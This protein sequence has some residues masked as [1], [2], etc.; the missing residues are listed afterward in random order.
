MLKHHQTKIQ[1]PIE[2]SQRRLISL[3]KQKS[4]DSHEEKKVFIKADPN[5]LPYER[6]GQYV[7]FKH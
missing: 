4:R 1:K 7:S 3:S 5:Y 6:G 2:L